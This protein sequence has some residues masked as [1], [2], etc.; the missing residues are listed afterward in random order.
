MYETLQMEQGHFKYPSI[1]TFNIF[2][3]FV[4]TKKG[5]EPQKNLRKMELKIFEKK[6]NNS[7]F[8]LGGLSTFFFSISGGVNNFM[9]GGQFFHLKKHGIR[10]GEV[11][12]LKRSGFSSRVDVSSLPK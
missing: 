6:Q 8:F 4:Q 7:M 3:H 11:L 1:C 10:K 12:K 9:L 2:L 5:R